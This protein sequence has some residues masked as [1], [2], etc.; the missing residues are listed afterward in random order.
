M[1]LLE[2]GEA[3][4][5]KKQFGQRETEKKVMEYKKGAY[6]GELAI[7]NNA[8]RVASVYAKVFFQK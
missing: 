3:Y 2:K 8:P 6:F 4:A 7:M 5:T 1:F